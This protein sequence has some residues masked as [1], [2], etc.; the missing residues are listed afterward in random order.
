MFWNKYILG[1]PI[2]IK[3]RKRRTASVSK[4]GLAGYPEKT[5]L[6]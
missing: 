1:L 5:Y 3:A 2:M 6:T 4:P